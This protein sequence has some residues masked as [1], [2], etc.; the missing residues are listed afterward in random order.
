MAAGLYRR[1][2]KANDNK[3]NLVPDDPFMLIFGGLTSPRRHAY[4]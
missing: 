4:R 1:C 2:K 3:E